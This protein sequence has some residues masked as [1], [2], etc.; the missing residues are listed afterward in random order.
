MFSARE[1]AQLPGRVWENEV[2][3]AMIYSDA[4]QEILR[5]G[6]D[7]KRVMPLAGSL[8]LDDAVG[9]LLKKAQAPELFPGAR[10]PEAAL[11]GLWL[12]FSRL[13]E[14]HE[15][16]Q[17]IHSVEGRFWHGIMHRREPDAGNAA[18]WFR[19][20]GR[21]PVFEEL[22]EA[23]G[24]AR[25]DPFAFIDQCEEAWR[26]PG[27][28]MEKDAMELQLKEWRLLFAWCARSGA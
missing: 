11:S 23:A 8:A 10:H 19:R 7:G 1:S 5:L 15:I 24:V 17:N 22:A 26:K 4:V 13:D 16:S 25:W 6:G 12:Y 28:A 9:R 2:L 20:V 18:Y 27:S 14:S 3:S 21:H